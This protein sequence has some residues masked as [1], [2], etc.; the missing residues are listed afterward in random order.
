MHT[1]NGIG[2]KRI[3]CLRITAAAGGKSKRDLSERTRAETRRTERVRGR[4]IHGP[5]VIRRPGQCRSIP[6]SARQVAPGSPLRPYPRRR[7]IAHANG[8]KIHSSYVVV[9]SR[10]RKRRERE[11]GRERAL[12]RRSIHNIAC[13][14]SVYPGSRGPRRRDFSRRVTFF[15]TQDHDGTPSGTG[16]W[17]PHRLGRE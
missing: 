4:E 10:G 11:R 9:V 17:Y 7:K 2:G 12:T 15:I 5:P 8:D 1:S 13:L 16:Q 3:R 14:P 6:R